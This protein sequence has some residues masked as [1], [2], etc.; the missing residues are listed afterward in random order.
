[1]IGTALRVLGGRD[2]YVLRL[3]SFEGLTQQE[4]GDELG[5]TQTQVSRIL[6]R[7]IEE[8]RASVDPQR[9]ALAV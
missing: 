3:R 4:I 9:D 1:M 7:S 8:L 2:R 5:V 6:S